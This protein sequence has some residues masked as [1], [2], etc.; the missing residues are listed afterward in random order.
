MAV[1]SMLFLSLAT[2]THSSLDVTGVIQDKNLAA[3]TARIALARLTREA[4]L[5][6][7]V[8]AA[9]QYRLAFT[10]TDITGDGADDTVEYSWS[11][12]TQA[13]TRTL[14]GVTET[15]AE[16][17]TLFSLEYQYESEDQV[18]IAAPGDVLPMSLAQFNGAG[19]DDDDVEDV[20]LDVDKNISYIRQYFNN[21]IEVPEVAS[22]TVRARTKVL[23]PETDMYIFLHNASHQRLAYGY[24]YRGQLT[25]AFQDITVPITWT[26]GAGT[27]ME[28]DKQYNWHFLPEDGLKYAGTIVYQHIKEG[29]GLGGGLMFDYY[30]SSTHSFGNMASLYFTVRGN[31]AITTPTRSTVPQSV[32]KKIKAS[33]IVAEG[34]ALTEHS[35]TCK[36]LNQ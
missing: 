16:N 21:T 8:T 6:K 33:I 18:T 34:D 12:N 13:L 2:F 29:P 7:V 24:L 26:G 4:A 19:S 10:C 9:E 20:E 14:N 23:P 30:D 15:F 11:S 3:Q 31:V 17:V 1:S 28:P 35:R 36:V 32:L 5:A 22:V 25:T 27:R